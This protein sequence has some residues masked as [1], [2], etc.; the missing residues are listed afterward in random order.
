MARYTPS[1]LFIEFNGL[2]GGLQFQ[3][4]PSGPFLRK[5]N[6]SRNDNP[7]SYFWNYPFAQQCISDWNNLTVLQQKSWNDNYSSYWDFYKNE[8]FQNGKQFFCKT[9]SNYYLTSEFITNYYDTNNRLPS[10]RASGEVFSIHDYIAFNKADTYTYY[11]KNFY[12]YAYNTLHYEYL[13][14]FTFSFGYFSEYSSRI[15]SR[16]LSSSHIFL[17]SSYKY[18]G[19]N[20]SNIANSN[21]LMIFASE[22]LDNIS[23][24]AITP[25][26]TLF[27]VIPPYIH[28]GNSFGTWYGFSFLTGKIYNTFLET[29]YHQFSV[30]LLDLNCVSKLIYS[31]N[32]YFPSFTKQNYT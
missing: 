32:L 14:N 7:Y 31:G 24:I 12:Q 16:I 30:F 4:G 11:I 15:V 25:Y 6:P 26:K 2:I 19:F 20:N 18:Y 17:N 1:S 9:R 21:G 27:C 28:T 3:G 8:Y 13:T 29:G 5:R 10:S 22:K 23:D